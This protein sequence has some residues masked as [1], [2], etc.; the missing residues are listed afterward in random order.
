MQPNPPRVFIPQVPS[1]Y[2]SSINRWVPTVN[3]EP[4]KAYGELK[5]LLPPEAGRMN[6]QELRALLARGLET[7]TIEDWILTTGDPTI[8]GITMVIA[9]RRLNGL[10]RI[11]RWDRQLKTYEPI[12]VQV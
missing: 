11:L 6:L 8:M 12:E 7:M 3:L 10:L 1:R 2:D 9:A 4:A 5:V